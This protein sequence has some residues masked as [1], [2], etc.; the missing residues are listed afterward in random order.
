[1]WLVTWNSCNQSSI[2]TNLLFNPKTSLLHTQGE[3]LAET[4]SCLNSPYINLNCLPLQLITCPLW[5]HRLGSGPTH[6]SEPVP[7]QAELWLH[8]TCWQVSPDLYR[9]NYVEITRNA[10]IPNST[11]TSLIYC[12][13]WAGWG[14]AKYKADY[15][16]LS[17]PS[18]LRYQPQ[19]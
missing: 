19:P 1:V 9:H 13:F 7:T 10:P 15:A 8:E 2:L 16:T 6:W 11:N 3:N 4:L 12:T 14:P 5:H 18:L 17:R